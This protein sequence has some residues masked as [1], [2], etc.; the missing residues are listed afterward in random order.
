MAYLRHRRFF[1]M[2]AGMGLAVLP[3]RLLASD[4]QVIAVLSSR[5]GPYQQALDGFQKA[6]GHMVPSYALSE[7]EPVIPSGTQ[8]I[9]AIGGKAA[10]HP[11]SSKPLLIYC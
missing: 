3:N 11:Y 1:L 4:D 6:Y 8:V 10:L 2:L 9:L 7:G 5:S